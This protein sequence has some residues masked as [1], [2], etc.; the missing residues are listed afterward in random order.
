MLILSSTHLQFSVF[1]S[2]VV[3]R[4]ELIGRY[5]FDV[6]TVYVNAGHEF[7]RQVLQPC[8]LLTG[9]LR[10]VLCCP[11]SFTAFA[12]ICS[13]SR[14]WMTRM[15]RIKESRGTCGFRWQCWALATDWSCMMRKTALRAVCDLLIAVV[16]SVS[17]VWTTTT[18]VL[19]V[20]LH[21]AGQALSEPWTA[22]SNWLP[23]TC[24]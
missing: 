3:L 12:T 1:D 15:R 4:N 14:L 9:C 7:Y 5:Q 6:S 17:R 13:G 11:I 18:I 23:L 16:A 24:S 19:W 20:V 8:A 21:W 10:V 2:N 22:R